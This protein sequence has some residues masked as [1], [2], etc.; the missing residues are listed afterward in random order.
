[1]DVGTGDQKKT[2]ATT[3][4]E[5]AATGEISPGRWPSAVSRGCSECRSCAPRGQT[6]DQI[7]LKVSTDLGD[8]PKGWGAPVLLSASE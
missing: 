1:M 5:W 4:K 3:E 6:S 2:T 7:A 8:Q